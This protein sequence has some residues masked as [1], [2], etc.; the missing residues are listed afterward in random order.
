MATWYGY[1]AKERSEMGKKSN[2]IEVLVVSGYPNVRR[3]IM[4]N[5]SG[6]EQIRLEGQASDVAG[7]GALL[8][9]LTPDIVVIN[10]DEKGIK[11]LDAVKLINQK[12]DDPKILLLI[13]EYNDEK[14]LAALKMGVRGFLPE[15]VA[16]AD[17]IKCIR[18]ISNGEMWVRRRVMERLVQQFLT[19]R[20][21]IV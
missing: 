16:K 19:K 14:E 13:K 7:L 9:K 8:D 17:F 6:E 20:R 15:T 10:D 5:L 11:S 3:D 21:Q 18:A 4:G 2:L 12:V 1:I